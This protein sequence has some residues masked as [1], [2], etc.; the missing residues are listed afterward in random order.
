VS[1]NLVIAPP[2]LSQPIISARG[3]ATGAPTTVSAK[4]E[5]PSSAPSGSPNLNPGF[6]LDPAL[7][8]AV[9]QFFDEKGDV[10]QTI[11]SQKQ[12]QA[13][14]Q[15]YGTAAGDKQGSALD[16]LGPES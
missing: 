4:F 2:T 3:A 1:G 11:P 16:P 10:T 12:L 6:R 5:T 14:Q 13:Y 9:L 8:L 15:D 7:N